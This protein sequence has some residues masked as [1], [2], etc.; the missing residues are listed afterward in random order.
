MIE[1]HRLKNVVTFIQAILYR[2]HVKKLIN[3]LNA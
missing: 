1:T 2:F 3:A